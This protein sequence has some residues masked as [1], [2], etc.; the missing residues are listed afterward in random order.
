MKKM[1]RHHFLFLVLA[2][3]ALTVA[4][5]ASSPPQGRAQADLPDF[6]M[7]P[8]VQEDAIF[9]IG[10]AKL[11]TVNQ[12]ITMAESRA[13]Q[14]LAF[15]LNA[16][17]QAMITDYA[18]SAGTENSQASLEFSEIVGRQLTQTTLSGAIPVKREQA[19]DGT[20]WVLISYSKA[21]AA[22]AAANIIENEASKY[23]EFKAMEALKLMDQQ[24]ER[25][26]TKPEAVTQ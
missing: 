6:V 16:N 19:K 9:G 14:S 7:N 13:R 12:S 4:G 17:V 22:R 15:Q 24:L 2:L 5:C 26:S 11:S 20:F 23:A 8:P 10:S 18:R 3:T 21:D 25:I 1:N